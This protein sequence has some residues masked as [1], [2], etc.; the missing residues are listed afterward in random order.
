MKKR[1]NIGISGR[2]FLTGMG[3]G[4]LADIIFPEND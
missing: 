4:W 1:T 3:L 2:E